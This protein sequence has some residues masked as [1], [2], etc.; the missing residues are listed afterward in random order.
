MN[1]TKPIVVKRDK[2]VITLSYEEVV[3]GQNVNALE[4]LKKQSKKGGVI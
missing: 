3:D 2:T 4:H 1:R